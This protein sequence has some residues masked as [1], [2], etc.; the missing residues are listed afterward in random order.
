MKSDFLEKE[1]PLR[2]SSQ[3]QDL[4]TLSSHHLLQRGEPIVP[5]SAHKELGW[6]FGRLIKLVQKKYMYWKQEIV[7]EILEDLHFTSIT[8]SSSFVE[9]V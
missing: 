2:R 5:L 7:Q 6:P 8:T 3:I 1:I 4:F 9:I